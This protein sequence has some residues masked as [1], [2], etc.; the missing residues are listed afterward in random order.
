MLLDFI[1]AVLRFSSSFSSSSWSS[2]S[3]SSPSFSPALCC[4]GQ[5][6]ISTASCR[7]QWAAPGLDR[8]A[9]ERS[10]RPRTSAARKNNA[11]RYV[12]RNVRRHAR[13]NVRR[14][15]KKE[16]QKVSEEISIEMPENMSTKNARRYARKNI[17]RYVRNECQKISS[18]QMGQID[19]S[20][21]RCPKQ[22]KGRGGED[23]SDEI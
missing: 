23:N 7:S 4:N 16:C 17:R 15:V 10:G 19:H 3:F 18:Y 11:R 5:R 14:Y 20:G 13:K 2:S 9:S 8:G 6:R 1:R 21:H 22:E 12:R